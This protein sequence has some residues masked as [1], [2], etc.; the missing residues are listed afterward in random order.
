MPDTS[1][2]FLH[3][4]MLGAQQLPLYATPANNAGAQNQFNIFNAVLVAGFN[5]QTATKIVVVSGVATATFG[6]SHGFELDAVV[7][8]S[9]ALVSA[10]NGE[11]RV[12]SVPSGTS[13]TFDATGVSDQ[14][15]LS[16][17][18]LAYAPLGWGLADS[19][20]TLPATFYSKDPAG[21][22]LAFTLKPYASERAT[23]DVYR[24]FSKGAPA[25]E[26][27]LGSRLFFGS[28]VSATTTH[29][30]AW[31]VF[32]DA[33]TFYMVWQSAADST[34]TLTSLSNGLLTAMGDFEP[35]ATVD[36][37]RAFYASEQDAHLL[38]ASSNSLTY[39]NPGSMTS[40]MWLAGSVGGGGVTDV[41]TGLETM[42][43]GNARVAGASGS[44]VTSSYPNAPDS[45]LILSRRYIADN[46]GVRGFLRGLYQ[47]P[48]PC[49]TAFAPFD[50]IEGQ[51][52]LV[53]R[54]LIAVR[55]GVGAS[56]STGP[57]VTF[58]D[59]TGPWA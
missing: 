58:F 42:F 6:A 7:L 13:L 57:G 11:K 36:A 34:V 20:T 54:R 46:T 3:S 2:K 47:S 38:S 16:G 30:G 21:T 55:C 29:T 28:S 37:H 41:R 10:L 25:Q 35:L 5:T 14:T 53:G 56:S 45:S 4:G 33:R 51:G 27:K 18:T 15:L 9:A 17:A 50:R 8:V 32:G 40:H 43:D 24:S 44:L 49:A 22:G 39:L 12:L 59:V 48:Q 1:V 26:I 52:P 19:A 31:A 23:C